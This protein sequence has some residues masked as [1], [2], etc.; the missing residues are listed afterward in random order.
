[1]MEKYDVEACGNAGGGG[2]YE[3][4]VRL[5]PYMNVIMVKFMSV[6]VVILVD[7]IATSHD[8]LLNPFNGTADPQVV[9]ANDE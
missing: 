8:S 4:Q 6:C 3:V 5:Q 2:E 1:M 7:F 9:M